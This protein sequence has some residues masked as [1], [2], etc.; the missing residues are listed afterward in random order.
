MKY[1]MDGN[2]RTGSGCRP[3]NSS[4]RDN[5]RPVCLEARLE[6]GL[7]IELLS[8]VQTQP[9]ES[10]DAKRS[11]GLEAGATGKLLENRGS[12]SYINHFFHNLHTKGM[13]ICPQKH[14]GLY[15]PA[16]HGP[17]QNSSV[18]AAIFSGDFYGR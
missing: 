11:L 12:L 13:Q 7:A 1:Q 15:G 5:A 4:P 6:P 10:A 14:S 8:T 9:Q 18:S 3:M 2:A 17:V 16:S